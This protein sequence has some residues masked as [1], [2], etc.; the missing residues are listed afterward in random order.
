[1]IRERCKYIANHPFSTLILGTLVTTRTRVT[2]KA[3]LT[4]IASILRMP[5]STTKAKQ[6]LKLIMVQKAP[7][8]W[9]PRLPLEETISAKTCSTLIQS[10]QAHWTI[11]ECKGYKLSSAVRG[12]IQVEFS[13]RAYLLTNR[14]TLMRKVQWTSPPQHSSGETI[15]I[16]CRSLFLRV[17]AASQ[18]RDQGKTRGRSI[19]PMRQPKQEK[20]ITRNHIRHHRLTKVTRSIHQLVRS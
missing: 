19:T 10:K 2:L 6:R 13:V 15:R 1:V 20:T 8:K 17:G 4:P 5:I 16:C 7:R 14:N 9:T 18:A 12:R 11:N 3:S